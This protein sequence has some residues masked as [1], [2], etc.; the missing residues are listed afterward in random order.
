MLHKA[1]AKFVCVYSMCKIEKIMSQ[2][3][4]QKIMFFA[5][6]DLPLAQHIPCA[7]FQTFEFAQTDST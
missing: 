6:L 1:Y 7:N 5:M 2:K 4:L 3:H